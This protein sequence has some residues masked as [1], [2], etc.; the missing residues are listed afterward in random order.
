MPRRFIILGSL[1][2]FLLAYYFFPYERSYIRIP[3]HFNQ[4][5]IPCAEIEIE[6]TKCFVEIVTGNESSLTLTKEILDKISKTPRG[7]YK[8]VNLQGTPFSSPL[9]EIPHLS[10]SQ[11]QV[12]HLLVS[13]ITPDFK[14]TPPVQAEGILGFGI[15]KGPNTLLDFH[16]NAFFLVR[17]KTKLSL[18]EKEG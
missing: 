15:L 7:V 1:L 12:S 11:L 10:L 6:G 9:Y 2:L 14:K 18:L 17:D 16:N 3:V 5:H 8:S 13:E 4:N